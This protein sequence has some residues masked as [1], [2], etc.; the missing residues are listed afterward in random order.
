VMWRGSGLSEPVWNWPCGNTGPAWAWGEA[1]GILV[2]HLA[3]P[4]DVHGPLLGESDELGQPWQWHAQQSFFFIFRKNPV[5][6]PLPIHENKTHVL[7][8]AWGEGV[9]HCGVGDGRAVCVR[10]RLDGPGTYVSYV[11]GNMTGGS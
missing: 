10:G 3:V 5:T 2:S 11:V 4:H 1:I 8:C 6:G 7:T 9:T